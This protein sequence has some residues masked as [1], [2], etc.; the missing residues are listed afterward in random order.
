[1]PFSSLI[2]N[3]ITKKT[4]S[5]ILFHI[6]LLLFCTAK[7]SVSFYYF[8]SILM[9]SGRILLFAENGIYSYNQD[10]QSENII[11]NFTES[12]SSFSYYLRY[13]SFTQLSFN[14]NNYVICI[15][16]NSLYFISDN[17][18]S[19]NNLVY[20][21]TIEELSE[22]LT[23][24]FN[25]NNYFFIIF[26]K[27]GQL[28]INKYFFNDTNYSIEKIKSINDGGNYV[29]YHTCEIMFSN[30]LFSEIITCFTHL[31]SM[32][33]FLYVS[34]F[35]I[36]NLTKIS[37][38][39]NCK[40][41]T[42]T[43]SINIK[44][45]VN[46]EKSKAFICYIPGSDTYCLV[47]DIN[48]NKFS[49]IKKFFKNCR[50]EP[51]TLMINYYLEKEEFIFNCQSG[52]NN[53]IMVLDDN[54]DI[55]S[56]NSDY[57]YCYNEFV[58]TNCSIPYGYGVL[59][60]KQKS[61]YYIYSVCTYNNELI[62]ASQNI[63]KC[64]KECSNFNFFNMTTNSNTTSKNTSKDN[65][66]DTSSENTSEDSK[67]IPQDKN[68]LFIIN[69]IKENGII[70]GETTI[71]KES[72]IENLKE[73][74]NEI[75]IGEIYI[76]NGEDYD[77]KIN[78]INNRNEG[79]NVNF[80][81][82]EEILR[83]EYN[84]SKDSILTILQIEI[85]K[86]NEQVLNN[87][88]EYA[89]Y[90][91]N[92]NK[93]NL[94]KCENVKITINYEIKNSTSLNI[95]KIE[96]FSDIGINIFDINEDFFNDICYPY[97]NNKTDIIL[98]DRVNDI[99]QNY[100]LCDNG[101]YIENINLTKM[102]VSCECDVKTEISTEIE[103]IEFSDMVIDTFE[104]SNINILKCYYLVFNIN[105]NVNNIG[106]WI[107]FIIFLLEIILYIH[108]FIYR[109]KPIKDFILNE[110]QKND[111]LYEPPKQKKNISINIK[112]DKTKIRKKSINSGRTNE[113]INC[114]KSLVL[115][116]SSSVNNSILQN[117][118]KSELKKLKAKSLKK[119]HSMENKI[120]K[121]EK[122][123]KKFDKINN[124][125][126]GYYTFIKINAN[127]KRIKMDNIYVLNIYTFDET[128]KYEKRNF[129]EIFWVVLLNIELILH[130]FIFKSVIELKS[131]R[132]IF[133][134]F[135]IATQLAFNAL[136]YVNSKIS[137]RYHYT[138]NNLYIYSLVNSL[139]ISISSSL[140]S[141]LV[142][143]ISKLIHSK[144]QIE[145]VF[146]EEENKMRKNK[147]YK[148]SI[149]S[150]KTINQKVNEILEKLNIK[151]IIFLTLNL[152]LLLFYFY[153]VTAFCAV[154]KDTQ[155]SWISDCFVSLITYILIEMI[156]AFFDSSIYN[157]SI[158][159]QIKCLYNLSLFVYKFR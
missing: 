59:Y 135:T 36:N 63:V 31:N 33:S 82:C 64:N 34:S 102:Q 146:K 72:I 38:L 120:K 84:I 14:Q 134:I 107:F 123:K 77:I 106:F 37:S 9:K 140:V 61:N 11:L 155:I 56:D 93:L 45:A 157:T 96:Y 139:V 32:P 124:N 111:Y 125:F 53:E 47:Y 44:S 122:N 30:E 66:N 97:S 137:N 115:R 113:N 78:P 85:D 74:I 131:L 126:S 26:I 138:G 112:N 69:T 104:N 151:I 10:F 65:S 68:Q 5:I 35:D 148:I 54:C 129:W 21:T 133:F 149:K 156:I 79:S 110:M 159:Q 55:K 20:Q 95:S 7:N 42:T 99:Y 15:F 108:Y 88:I 76:I 1:M 28:Y 24:L 89:I 2:N 100:S 86:K 153:F 46:K 71:Q 103:E 41:E 40:I 81:Q 18:N 143:I 144:Y 16:K 121:A 116:N 58:I 39:S 3:I 132:I 154:Y 128:K 6:I 75:E 109:L 152:I 101:C 83:N 17:T 80:S 92:K 136:F 119:G 29:I 91:E 73:L 62:I 43:S 87:Q 114:Y 67:I 141:I 98:S 90:D 12:I 57:E 49:D 142:I 105:N 27:S 94:S 50:G 13:I 48:N 150:K 117:Y 25:Y 118:S 23:N 4:S 70:K 158:T 52:S 60:L 147:K 51:D 127:N 19:E 145:E 130:T 22:S 8:S